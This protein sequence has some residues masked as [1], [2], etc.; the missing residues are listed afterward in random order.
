MEAGRPSLRPESGPQLLRGR[1][2][3]GA[4]TQSSG[5]LTPTPGDPE[6]SHLSEGHRV[7]SCSSLAIF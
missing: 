7:A 1:L 3:L 6:A 4:T 2:P 5:S